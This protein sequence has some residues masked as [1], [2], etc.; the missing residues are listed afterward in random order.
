VRR[1]RRRASTGCTGACGVKVE[2]RDGTP[3][4]DYNA[5]EEIEIHTFAVRLV[6]NSPASLGIRQPANDADT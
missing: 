2:F 3:D 1:W 6:R 4:K 5:D